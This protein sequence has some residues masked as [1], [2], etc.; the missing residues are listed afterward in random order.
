MSH[1]YFEF[2]SQVNDLSADGRRS[3]WPYLD[4]VLGPRLPP[5]ATKPRILDIGCGAGIVLEWLRHRGYAL[6]RGID[7]DAGQVEF[8][9]GLGLDVARVD[10]VASW[11]AGQPAADFVI[12]KDVLEHVA[13][14]QVENLL[15]AVR[16]HLAPRGNLYLAVPNASSSFAAR[17]RYIDATH[18]RSYTEHSLRWQLGSAGLRITELSG[19]DVWAVGSPLGHAQQL[20]RRCFRLWRRLEALAEFGAEGLKM[21]LSLN[22]VAMVERDE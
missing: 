4:R 8:A 21:P 16:D 12:L 22:L 19:D 13:A 7:S 17:W 20:L 18:R 6:A 14:E 2:Y 1:R 11:L 3:H 5:A 15:V 9:A 10:D